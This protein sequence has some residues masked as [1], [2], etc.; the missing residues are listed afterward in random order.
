MQ[1]A[2]EATQEAEAEE[3]GLVLLRRI[4]ELEDDVA[5]RTRNISFGY[6]RG[7]GMIGPKSG[8]IPSKPRVEPLDVAAEQ[9]PHE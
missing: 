8:T 3:E 5:M 4:H 6:V 9:S 1:A 2:P 7:R